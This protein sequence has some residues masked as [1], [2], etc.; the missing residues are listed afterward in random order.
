[1]AFVPDAHSS[2]TS[3][4]GDHL[5]VSEY[6]AIGVC[7]ILLGLIYVASVFLYIHL[8][9]RNSLESSHKNGLDSQ[10]L[11]AVEEGLVK[12]N[13]L[14]SISSHFPPT[15]S[16]YS[17]TNS[18]DTDVTPDIIQHHDDRKKHVCPDRQFQTY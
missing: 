7:S 10:S 3:S 18:S 11:G 1:M 8:K 4:D 6:I 9:K 12:N 15:D 13:P 16:A 2:S 17:D 14:L 5:S